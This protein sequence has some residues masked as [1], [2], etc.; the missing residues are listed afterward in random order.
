M[1]W[2]DPPWWLPALAAFAASL[3]GTLWALE[4][5]HRQGLL[6][7][8][9]ARRSHQTPTARGGGL[10]IAV[11]ALMRI[12]SPGHEYFVEEGTNFEFNR[13]F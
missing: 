10:G 11:A 9:G 12:L 1:P 2:S 3:L 13:G 7:H 5:A 4:H 6:D 8:P